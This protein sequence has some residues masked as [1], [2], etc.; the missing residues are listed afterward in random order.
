MQL[1]PSETNEKKLIEYIHNVMC[2]QSPF[3]AKLK[4]LVLIRKI[5]D[6]EQK[7]NMALSGVIEILNSKKIIDSLLKYFNP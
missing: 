7:L 2:K 4:S 1:C 6:K 3:D 5:L